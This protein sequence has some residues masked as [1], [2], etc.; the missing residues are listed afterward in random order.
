MKICL[1]TL[2]A[3]FLL[4]DKVFPNLGILQISSQLKKH[5]YDVTVHDDKVSKIPEGYDIYGIS[6]TTPQF[7]LAKEALK[8]IRGFKNESKVI[9]GGAHPT[10]DFESCWD[11][12]YIIKGDGEDAVTEA[13]AF[14]K[15]RVNATK[16]YIIG[17][18]LSQKIEDYPY[19]DR[20]AIDIKSYKY[21]ID[22]EL[23]TTIVTGRGCPFS[24]AFCCKTSKV[25]L[26]PSWHVIEEFRLLH[27]QYG[28][29]AFMIFDDIFILNKKRTI[30][31]C[32]AIRNY[33]FKL[34]CFVRADLVVKHDYE[35]L[36]TMADAGIVEVGMGIESGSN[37]ILKM[38]NKGETTEIMAKAIKMLKSVG[39]RVKGFII[40]GLPYENQ[41]TLAETRKFLYDNKLDDV[42]FTI[43]TPYKGSHI[44][45]NKRL[46]DIDWNGTEMSWYK[47]KP[48]QYSS[49]V[50]TSALSKEDIVEARINLEREFKKW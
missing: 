42:D 40:V 39:I 24:C 12:D 43:F 1:I 9:I 34:R 5:G 10:V 48:D 26:R 28:Y 25:K 50:F 13:L 19:A 15:N 46:Y 35:L 47:G 44:Y 32:E 37:L 27:F 31:I 14:H 6:S 17:K 38:I 41:K 4:N 45:N 30:E 23:A 11:F 33:N 18:Q 36:E 3:P 7:P 21:Y 49:N 2:P 29:K 8:R 16:P 20:D 22:N